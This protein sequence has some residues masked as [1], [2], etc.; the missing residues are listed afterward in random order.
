MELLLDTVELSEIKD[1][2]EY[3][4]L[5]GITSNPSIVKKTAPKDFFAHMRKIRSIIGKE[6]TLH[7]QVVAQDSETQLREAKRIFEEIDDRVFIKVPVT[8]QGL[9]TIRILK[10]EGKNVTAT[11]IYD[12]MQAYQAMAAGADYLAVYVNRI[13]SMGGDPF[14]LIRLTEERIA[15]DE[16]S[17]KVLGASYHS[18]QQVRDSLNAGAQSITVPIAYFRETYKNANIQSAV[19]QFTADFEAVYGKGKNLLDL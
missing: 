5:A 14:E 8:W 10:E 6:R 18:V 12:I 16:Y 9:R 17:C 3:F 15:M 11:A 13:A 1:A 2:A 19:D 4:P 7:I